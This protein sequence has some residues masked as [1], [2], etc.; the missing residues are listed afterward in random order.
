MNGLD[1][2]SK[3]N[4]STSRE[5]TGS[6]KQY[7]CKL[8]LTSFGGNATTFIHNPITFNPPLN[9]ITNLHF[10]WLDSKGTIINNNDCDWSMTVTV[11]EHYEMPQIPLSMP[12]ITMSESGPSSGKPADSILS[13]A[14]TNAEAKEK[15]E[16]TK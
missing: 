4:Y 11:T 8:L 1:T 5:P 2:G 13:K 10:Q 16:E 7:Y 3:E 15:A 12:F 6:T 14:E 9:R